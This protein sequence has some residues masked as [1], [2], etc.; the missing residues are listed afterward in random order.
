MAGRISLRAATEKAIPD[1]SKLESKSA[2]VSQKRSLLYVPQYG[3]E[4]PETYVEFQLG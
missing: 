1:P 3:Q 4:L 2:C